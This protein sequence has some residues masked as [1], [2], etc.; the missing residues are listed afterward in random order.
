[1]ARLR[2][3]ARLVGQQLHLLKTTCRHGG[4]ELGSSELL[5]EMTLHRMTESMV[6]PGQETVAESPNANIHNTLEIKI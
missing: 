2:L 4:E 3:A 6:P 1:M 5:G